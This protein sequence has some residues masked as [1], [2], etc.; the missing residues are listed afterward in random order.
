MDNHLTICAIL[1]AG[2]D[3]AGNI[4][5]DAIQRC[6][7]AVEMLTS[8]KQTQLILCGGFGDHFN[9]TD[10]QHYKYLKKYIESKKS[11][12]EGA[13]L[14]YVDSYNTIDDIQGINTLLQPLISNSIK[15]VIITNDYHVLRASIL[16]KKNITSENVT[17][18]F[19]SVSSL[20]DVT[21]L[22]SRL[23]H[24]IRRIKEYLSE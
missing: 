18:Q 4:D 17:V 10:Q 3:D 15:L 12:F 23:E 19:L 9:I 13:I 5:S 16:A 24:E 6:D 14:G 1:G 11:N 21:L 8:N 20:K 7:L 22:S 2:N